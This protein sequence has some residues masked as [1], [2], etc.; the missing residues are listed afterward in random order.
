LNCYL[1]RI[2]EAVA[3]SESGSVTFDSL[4]L[5]SRYQPIFCVAEQRPFGY[6]GLLVAY[7]FD[8][9]TP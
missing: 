1:E 5:S 6:E 9:V 8:S 7:T 4:S 3:P 2:L